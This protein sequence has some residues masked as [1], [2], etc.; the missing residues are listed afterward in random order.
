MGR[1]P[2]RCYRQQKGKPYPKS[3]YC[4][5]VPDPKIRIYDAGQ[6]RADV[7][8]F[9]ACVHLA[10]WEKEHVTSEGLEAARVA[11]NKYMVKH[12]GKEA[13]HLRVRVH[14]YHVLRINKMLSCAG[15]DRLQTGMRGAFGKPNGLAARVQIGQVLMS[16]RCKDNHAATAHEAMRRA[17]FKFPGRQKIITSNKW[18]FTAFPREDF[19]KYREEG[20]LQNDG[21]HATLISNHG[22]LADRESDK[23]FDYPAKIF[24]IPN[25]K[26]D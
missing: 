19:L 26:E 13:F 24:N 6:K 18:G 10:S 5:G 23:I 8:L 9:P 16:I 22:P 3:R 2:A 12:A 1:R 20:R 21:V 25:H 11:A 15:A 4:R 14:P 17:K 7:D